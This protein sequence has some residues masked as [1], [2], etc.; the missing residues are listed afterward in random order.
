MD[1]PIVYASKCLG[2]ANCRY[3]GITIHDEF[4]EKLR[5][6]VEYVT[7]CPEVEIGLGVPREPI[8]IIAARGE[9][10]L[11]QP[12]TGKDVTKEMNDFCM[13][14]VDKLGEVDGFILKS[15]SPSCGIK[16]VKIYSSIEKGSALGKDMG[17]FGAT[18]ITHFA[19]YPIEDEGRITN[20]RIREHFLTKLFTLFRFRQIAKKKTMKSLVQFHT[21]NKFML[22]AY[23]QKSLKILGRVVANLERR[24]IGEVFDLYRKELYNAFDKLP[25]VVSN[26]NVLMH[27]LGYFSDKL[28]AKEKS[29]FLDSLGKYRTGKIPLSV[30]LALLNSWI[31][32][33]NE[34][35]LSQQ[36]YFEPYPT[37]LVEIADSGKGRE[38]S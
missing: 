32:R 18:I 12:A 29:F 35:Y 25:R 4:I 20:F 34:P 15:R 8:R 28:V 14:F 21:E 7:A 5:P 16:D 37:A 11:V 10:K 31:V 27:A 17:F 2:F 19:K 3:N 1:K 6:Y 38:L 30:N 33:F 24:S 26:I 22:M 9:R 36:K 23:R 13:R